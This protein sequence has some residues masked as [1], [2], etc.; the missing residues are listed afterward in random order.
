MPHS[1][2]VN[3]SLRRARAVL[4]VMSASV[5]VACGTLSKEECLTADWDAIGERDGAAGYAPQSRLAGH[6]KA[7]AKAGVSPDQVLWRAGFERGLTRYCTPQS[8]LHAGESGGSY[9]NVCPVATEAEFLAAF[10]V[11]KAAHRARS[12]LDRAKRAVES[13]Q[14]EVTDKLKS[15][16]G[17]TDAQRIAAQYDIA[18]LNSQILEHQGDIL[19][20]SAEVARADQAV[21]NYRQTLLNRE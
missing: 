5:L 9:N 16:A 8:G 3:D 13:K 11:G 10:N 19:R 15:F 21:A 2:V 12:D 1:D 14:R 6:A 4:L 7:C 17:M 20:L 18:E